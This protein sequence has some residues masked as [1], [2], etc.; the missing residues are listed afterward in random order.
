MLLMNKL[1]QLYF[2]GRNNKISPA[3]ANE[4]NQAAETG[5]SCY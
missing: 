1:C 4:R 3:T 5:L 2:N